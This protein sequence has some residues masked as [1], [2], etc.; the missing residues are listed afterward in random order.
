MRRWWILWALGLLNAESFRAPMIAQQAATGTTY[1]LFVTPRDKRGTPVQ[2]FKLEGL[3][4]QLDKREVQVTSVEPANSLP[5]VLG[6]LIDKSGSRRG[7][8]PGAEEE[9]AIRFLE[10]EARP[11]SAGF[12]ISYGKYAKSTPDSLLDFRSLIEPVRE[13]VRELPWGPSELFDTIGFACQRLSKHSGR[14]VLILV[15]DGVDNASKSLKW[16]QE[17]LDALQ[18]FE[19]TIYVVRVSS[20]SL[21]R[22]DQRGI[23]FV[24]QLARNSDGRAIVAKRKHEVEDAFKLFSEELRA[25]LMIRY[26]TSAPLRTDQPYKFQVLSPQADVRF[27]A[28]EAFPFPE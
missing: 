8:L 9:P 1:R 27:Q 13:I 2:N 6:L 24:Q 23:S 15:S 10:R 14:R 12:V 17:T 16:P 5:L 4:L 11:T 7:Q 21:S 20:L 18:R 22:E 25:Q 3:R 28:R 26:T 19:A